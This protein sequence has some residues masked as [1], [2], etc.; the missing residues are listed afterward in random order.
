MP[1]V[2]CPLSAS[3]A[4]Y[5]WLYSDCL[6]LWLPFIK[7]S[8]IRVLFPTRDFLLERN[9]F[10]ALIKRKCSANWMWAADKQA[11]LGR[12]AAPVA[13]VASYKGPL[14]LTAPRVTTVLPSPPT[15]LP[16]PPFPQLHSSIAENRAKSPET[17]ASPPFSIHSFSQSCHHRLLDIYSLW[18]CLDLGVASS[19][20]TSLFHRSVP[21][22]GV[23]GLS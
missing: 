16:Q 10:K 1:Q 5:I 19:L 14:T 21:T 20:V 17:V 12:S 9:F 18:P 15:A 22:M 23:R 8:A 7:N 3:P 11:G 4:P 2:L 13:T 6:I